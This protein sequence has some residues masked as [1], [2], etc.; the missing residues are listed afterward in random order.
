[1]G[2]VM[3]KF[4]IV[5]SIVLLLA[6]LLAACGTSTFTTSSVGEDTKI[7]VTDADDGATSESLYV[8]IGKNRIATIESALDKGQ[9]QIDITEA[10]VFKNEDDSEDVMLG[11]IYATVTVGPDDKEEIELPQGDYIYQLTAIGTTNGTVTID[12]EKKQ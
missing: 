2:K 5:L 12:V 6:M 7:E 1:G 4:S 9:L 11:D 10:I 8:S 3:K